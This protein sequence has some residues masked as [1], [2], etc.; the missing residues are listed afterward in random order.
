MFVILTPEERAA[1]DQVLSIPDELD[2][3]PSLF[4]V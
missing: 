2:E 1:L 4:D 3:Q